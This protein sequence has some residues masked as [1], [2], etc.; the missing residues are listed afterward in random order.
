MEDFELDIII[1]RQAARIESCDLGKISA[2]AREKIRTD[3][4]GMLSK[5]FD[6]QIEDEIKELSDTIIAWTKRYPRP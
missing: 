1:D 4:K 3:V 5:N 6:F 2:P